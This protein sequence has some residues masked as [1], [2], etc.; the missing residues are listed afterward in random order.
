MN[1][2]CWQHN[3]VHSFTAGEVEQVVYAMTGML[4]DARREDA[5]DSYAEYHPQLMLCPS[6]ALTLARDSECYLEH[7]EQGVESR[8]S[9]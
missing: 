6:E 1:L 5:D 7:V 9:A 3:T 4:F 2:H 8:R